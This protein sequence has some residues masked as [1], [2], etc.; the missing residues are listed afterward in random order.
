MKVAVDDDGVAKGIPE[1]D[2]CASVAKA[3][4]LPFWQVWN[5]ARRAWEKSQKE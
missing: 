2:S 3:K 4:D 1:Y 5:E